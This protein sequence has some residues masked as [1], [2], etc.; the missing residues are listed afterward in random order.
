MAQLDFSTGKE[1]RV[2]AEVQG[3]PEAA[4]SEFASRAGRIRGVTEVRGAGGTI[5][6]YVYFN[7][8][9]TNEAEVGE[10]VTLI[11]RTILGTLP[12]ATVDATVPSATPATEPPDVPASSWTGMT[13]LQERVAAFKHLAP[14]AIAAVDALIADVEKSGD[15]GGP[16]LDDRKEALEA[17]RALRDALSALLAAAETPGFLWVDGEGLAASAVQFAMRA[18]DKLKSDPMPFAVSALLVTLF[19]TLGCPGIGGWLAAASLELQKKG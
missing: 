6:F 2:Y 13:N 7:P 8:R 10:Q 18:G 1:P 4:K 17:L 11:A 12:G 19:T 3:W 14:V 9:E 5:G 15:N 16:P